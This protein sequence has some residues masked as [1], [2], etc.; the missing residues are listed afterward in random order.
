MLERIN[1][2]NYPQFVDTL[3]RDIDELVQRMEQNPH[4][5]ENQSEDDISYFIGSNLE[6][7]GYLATFGEQH[8]GSVD[9]TIRSTT[10]KWFWTSE[11][12]VYRKLDDMREG[13]LQFT[14][15]YSPFDWQDAR[16]GAFIYVKAGDA[17]DK[18]TTWRD[19][20]KDNPPPELTLANCPT[21]PSFSFYSS[22]KHQNSGLPMSVRHIGIVLNVAPK[23]KSARGAAKHTTNTP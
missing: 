12:K 8:G 7:M 16:G 20:L 10:K 4:R 13:F 3:H 2:S 9:I 1:A 5:F 15:R 19:Y 21:R 14:T 18:I 23:D 6:S 22:H 17:N 11:A